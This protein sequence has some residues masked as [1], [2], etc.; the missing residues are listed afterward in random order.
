MA[1]IHGTPTGRRKPTELEMQFL[2]KFWWGADRIEEALTMAGPQETAAALRR[3]VEVCNEANAEF[4]AEDG[5]D[6]TSV[7]YVYDPAANKVEIT[8]TVHRWPE[9]D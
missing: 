1:D 7:S 5:P 8:I 4:N 9:E 3:L 2:D 6:G